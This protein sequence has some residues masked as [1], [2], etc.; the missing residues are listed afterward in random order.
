MTMKVETTQRSINWWINRMWQVHRYNYTLFS[1]KNINIHATTWM[2]FKNIMLTESS[3][4]RKPPYCYDS[5]YMKCSAKV[6]LQR[7]SK[8]V[9]AR[10][11]SGS[12]DSL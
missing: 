11:G 12:R 6:N 9:T 8:I 7:K 10:A 1:N 3:Q 2:D 5:I 4:H